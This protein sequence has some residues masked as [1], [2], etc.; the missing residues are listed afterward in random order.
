MGGQGRSMLLMTD[1]GYLKAGTKDLRKRGWIRRAIE[2][3]RPKF[4]S[5]SGEREFL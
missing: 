4:S 3:F 5:R 1:L 2:R